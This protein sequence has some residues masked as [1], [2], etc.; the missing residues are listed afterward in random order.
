[1]LRTMSVTEE[2]NM[3]FLPPSFP[4]SCSPFSF[5]LPPSFSSLPSFRSLFLSFFCSLHPFCLPSSLPYF[6]TPSFMNIVVHAL[7]FKALHWAYLQK[8][9][10]PGMQPWSQENILHGA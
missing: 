4:S 2:F 1:M 5:L 10:R 3:P 6:Y 8:F 9:P 7:P